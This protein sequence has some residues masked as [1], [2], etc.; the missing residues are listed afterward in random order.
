MRVKS[1]AKTGSRTRL[2]GMRAGAQ[3]QVSKFHG[4]VQLPWPP[5]QVSGEHVGK[6]IGM[7]EF[8][9]WCV[10]REEVSVATNATFFATIALETIYNQ[11]NAKAI[12]RYATN[13]GR[14]GSGTGSTYCDLSWPRNDLVEKGAARS[15]LGAFE[16]R[17]TRPKRQV[18]DRFARQGVTGRG[19]TGA[20]LQLHLDGGFLKCTASE[21]VSVLM[22]CLRSQFDT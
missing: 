6:F 20:P 19:W 14:P 22:I 5:V 16:A 21:R 15:S 9:G 10:R 8:Q 13:L 11:P 7:F 4:H 3:G 1:S 2:V 17:M 12:P 18:R